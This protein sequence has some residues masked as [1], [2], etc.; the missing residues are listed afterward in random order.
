MSD[1]GFGQI[2]SPAG[3]SPKG[4][5][6]NGGHVVKIVKLPEALSNNTKALKLEGEVTQ[7]NKNGSVR[8]STSKGDI[9][10]QV[11]GNKQPQKG[12]RVEIDLPAGRPPR[13]ATL[14]Q[15]T[16]RNTPRTTT[17]SPPPQTTPAPQTVQITHSVARPTPAQP[18]VPPAVQ[19]AVLQGNASNPATPQTR[20]IT[21]EAVIRLLPAPPAQAQTIVREY[22]QTLPQPQLAAL[23]R[24]ELSANLIVQNAEGQLSQALLQAPKN[25]LTQLNLQLQNTNQP[26]LKN[27]FFQ[28]PTIQQTLLTTPT[29]TPPSTTIP[30]LL[31]TAIIQ[32]PQTATLTPIA[33]DPTNP[34]T[35]ASSRLSQIDIQVLKITPPNITLTPPATP[36]FT[37]P[38][39]SANNATTI[40]AQVTSF[41]QGG[42]P[43]VT[44][45][46][47]GSSLPQNFILQ[48]NS[49]NLQLGTQLQIS[50][51]ATASAASTITT[52][53]PQLSTAN[54][55]LQGFQWP[56]LDELYNGL[57]RI[58][59]Q[60]AA[61]LSRAL[62]NAG[63]PAQMGA[64]AMMFIAAVRSG[65][66]G[67]WLG[68]KKIDLIQRM[69][70]G[71]I[72]GR[73][74]QNSAN[75]VQPTAAEVPTASEWRAVPLPMFWEGEIHKITLY[76]KQE[77]QNNQKD[78][79]D[80]N[81]QTRFV[82]DLSLSRMGDIQLDGLLRDKRLDLVVRT[83][84]SFS[85]PMQQTMRQ[86]YTTALGSTE[87]TGDLNF[88]GSTNNWV[89]V[90]QEKEQ[91]GVEV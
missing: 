26:L 58:S 19:E 10:V 40:T 12:Q 21:P 48:F 65:D 29:G 86:A 73:L 64:A 23:A 66:I 52:P 33:L 49:N 41:T 50:P 54:P 34:A 82:F 15:T 1:S 81:G 39:T 61:S 59:P 7:Q 90:L 8:I 37:P 11:R 60:A 3:T 67:G 76:T 22:L 18:P 9:D 71:N 51:Q 83:Q 77:N 14:R 45:Q 17:A 74:V 75:A 62:P 6:N 5:A 2:S 38:L 88:Q 35:L 63:N 27:S 70:R 78:N 36:P 69:G 84:N 44:L 47:P 16:V 43:L 53:L 30:T 56:A 87:L 57:L 68:D 89:H 28:T 25:S 20:A 80:N 55:L 32:A 46:W 31:N 42:L 72:L 79:Q 4:G 24:T 85:A 13:Q 91:L